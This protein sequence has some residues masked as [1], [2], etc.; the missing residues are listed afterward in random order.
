MVYFMLISY[1]R[2]MFINIIRHRVL[3]FIFLLL[4]A[5]CLTSVFDIEGL[6]Y[7]MRYSSLVLIHEIVFMKLVRSRINDLKSSVPD[8]KVN[9]TCMGPTWVLSA[10][11]GPHVDPMNLIIRGLIE[12]LTMYELL[13]RPRQSNCCYPIVYLHWCQWYLITVNICKHVMSL[14]VFHLWL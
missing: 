7:G 6:W 5:V 13:L 11:D 4:R 1:Q 3:I 9:G 10:P 8:S 2:R 12:W 14:Y